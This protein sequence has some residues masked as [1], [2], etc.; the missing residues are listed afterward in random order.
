LYPVSDYSMQPGHI[1]A[2]ESG[3]PITV[4]KANK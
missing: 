1:V 3:L 4:T 2:F